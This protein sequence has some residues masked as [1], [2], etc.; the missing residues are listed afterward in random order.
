M[1]QFDVFRSPRAGTYPLVV[2]IQADIHA[3][4][5]TR[6]VVPLIARAR[7]MPQPMTRLTPVIKVLRDDYVVMFPLMAAVPRASLGELV[8]SLAV[9]R[10]TLI[11]ALDLLFT[12]V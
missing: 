8:G 2:D 10:A 12:G 4:L 7:Y 9:H 3:K 1:P 6:V 5:A 11:A